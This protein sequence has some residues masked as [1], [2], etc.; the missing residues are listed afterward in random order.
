[1]GAHFTKYDSSISPVGVVYPGKT[2]A[3]N[4]QALSGSF[5]DATV[6]GN[7]LVRDSR[8]EDE[9]SYVFSG[10]NIRQVTGRDGVPVSYIWDYSNKEPIAKVSNATSDQIAYTSF[11]ADGNGSWTI[12][13]G[14]RDTAAMTG[15]QSYSL[16]NGSLSRSGLNS[17]TSYIVSYWSKQ[18]TP[19]TVSGT[20]STLT[21]KMIRGWTYF[22]HTIKGT[23]SLTISGGGNIDELR[24][25][26][27]TAQMT[28][29]TYRPGV[30]IS[31]QCDVG[32][33]I[34]YYFYDGLG[35]LH[36]MKDQDGNIVKTVDYH[37][38]GQ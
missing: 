6:S 24:L 38:M 14:T 5:T 19:Y 33:R 4:L 10:G 27:A 35:R 1:M 18:N 31:S 16:G 3:V 11:E 13:S 9:A 29:Y 8:Y 36:H 20:T 15:N 7:T 30:G 32:N 17:G 2:Q 34:T 37:Y 26:P 28:T 22:E 12:P 25:Y 21:G 23:S